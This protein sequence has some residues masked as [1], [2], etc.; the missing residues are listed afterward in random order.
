MALTAMK[1]VRNF[2]VN[3]VFFLDVALFCRLRGLVWGRV[4]CSCLV[5]AL[6]CASARGQEPEARGWV[7]YALTFGQAGLDGLDSTFFEDKHRTG[8]GAKISG[9][10]VIESLTSS[11]P[12]LV[13]GIDLISTI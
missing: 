7:S 6:V 9:G 4:C 5:V 10:V 13:I 11:Q 1:F 3:R 12:Q 8:L 2:F